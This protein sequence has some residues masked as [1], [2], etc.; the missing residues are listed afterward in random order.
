MLW[1]VEPL[2][3]YPEKTPCLIFFFN[4]TQQLATPVS[5]TATRPAI[6]ALEDA[7]HMGEG[8]LIHGY[9]HTM[10]CCRG[11][12]V[13]LSVF[14]QS[15][16]PTFPS[17]PSRR[18]FAECRIIISFWGYRPTKVKMSLN[19][20]FAL[21]FTFALSHRNSI[22]YEPNQGRGGHYLALG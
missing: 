14:A 6:I 15:G 2:S 1:R 12:A 16:W 21:Q 13:H 9:R 8:N 22:Q 5:Y 4:D 18:A 10:H 3:Y 19:S 7:S 17:R 20:T 11:S